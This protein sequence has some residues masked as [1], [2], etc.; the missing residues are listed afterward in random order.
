MTT[1]PKCNIDTI[2]HLADIHYPNKEG[3]RYGNRF[4]EYD[5]ILEKLYKQLEEDKSRKLIII[6]GD[7]FENKSNVDDECVIKVTDMLYKMRTYNCKIII[8]EGNHDRNINNI[9]EKT[10]LDAIFNKRQ[11]KDIFLLN[12]DKE[13]EIDGIKNIV[14]VN[15]TIYANEEITKIKNKDKNKLYIYLYHGQIQ[16]STFQNNIK[17]LKSTGEKRNFKTCD[18]VDHDFVLLGDIHKHQYLNKEKTI[19]YPGSFIQQNHGESIN[20]HGYIKWN[21]KNKTSE[22]IEL[23]NDYAFV[24]HKVLDI[25]NYE[26][27]DC[28]NKKYIRLNLLFNDSDRDNE[29]EY[30]KQ[31]KNKYNIIHYNCETIEEKQQTLSHS[32]CENINENINEYKDIDLYREYVKKRNI[33]E[34]TEII[35][36][37]DNREKE[38][39]QKE[40]EKE[41]EKQE[42]QNEK[43]KKNKKQKKH[44]VDEDEIDETKQMITTNKNIKIISLKFSYLFSYGQNNE[45]NFENMEKNL[46]HLIYGLNGS[47]KSNLVDCILFAIYETYSRGHG[48][49]ALNSDESKGTSEII[50]EINEINYKITRTI[51]ESQSSSSVLHIYKKEKTDENYKNICAENKNQ[52]EDKIIKIVGNYETMLLSSIVLF[53]NESFTNQTDKNRLQILTSLLG[54]D[55]YRVLKIENEKLLKKYNSNEITKL[56]TNLQQYDKDYELLIK[57]QEILNKNIHDK[58][59]K[60]QIEIEEN[61]KNEGR[62]EDKIST[63]ENKNILNIEKQHAQINKK[64]IEISENKTQI[65]KIDEN[66]IIILN[67]KNNTIQKKITNLEKEIKECDKI[68]MTIDHN[69]NIEKYTNEKIKL[70]H[71]NNELIINIKKIQKKYKLKNKDIINDIIEYEKKNNDMIQ[72]ELYEKETNVKLLNSFMLKQQKQK[73][74]FDTD[75]CSSCNN[76]K[77]IFDTDNFVNEIIDLNNKI[78]K[79]TISTKESFENN[80]TKIKELQELDISNN[81][82]IRN[83]KTIELLD[84]KITSENENMLKC[85]KFIEIT[86]NNK[87][88]TNQ[89]NILNNEYNKNNKQKVE[90]ETNNLKYNKIIQEENELIKNKNELSLIIENNTELIQNIKKHELIIE[91]KEK[92]KKEYEITEKEFI[93][94][95]DELK[96]FQ[97][98]N[99]EKQILKLELVDIIHKKNICEKINKLYDDGFNEY[100]IKKSLNTLEHKINDIILSVTDDFKI[101]FEINNNGVGLLHINKNKLNGIVSTQLSGSQTFISNVAFRLAINKMNM[102]KSNFLIIDEGFG[103]FDE[104]KLENI[105]NLFD[106]IR[107]QYEMCLI[108]SHVPIIQKYSDERIEI[109]CDKDKDSY[110]YIKSS[111]KII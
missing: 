67:E 88:I 21:V 31:I 29:A 11:L 99:K 17:V 1:K 13:Y 42:K 53:N 82:C 83:T 50:L 89:I 32:I 86:N 75:N 68:N 71:D 16:Q 69:K 5:K 79:K 4:D 48:K 76:N 46:I 49:Q 59:T 74:C 93:K 64:L 62:I 22:Y 107:K 60:I 55:K 92:L 19:A 35:T 12:E 97:K 3:K 110:S 58:I 52:N 96:E 51:Y 39:Q 70:T 101:K 6:V 26:I 27:K 37:I 15:T 57:E 30:K 63:T 38:K 84:M 34:S 7:T 98:N 85:T 102:I 25:K 80:K 73:Y 23:E 18:F 28:E 66:E 111:K 24:T 100:Y 20:N 33:L 94:C 44:I 61:S 103:T 56:T 54:I 65:I 9:N 106:M 72:Q 87:N 77:Q 2:Y 91:N 14:F 43:Q 90:Y 104:E 36:E 81:I 45:I 40:K 8:T 47:G 10:K 109:I 78:N 95:K 105:G 108:V 41:K